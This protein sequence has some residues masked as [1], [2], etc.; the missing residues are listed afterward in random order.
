[1]EYTVMDAVR[2][3]FQSWGLLACALGILFVALVI[4]NKVTGR[5]KDKDNK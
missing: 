4:L 2:I 1:M 5:K 3:A